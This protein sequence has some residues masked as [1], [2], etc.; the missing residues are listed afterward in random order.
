MPWWWWLLFGI[1]IGVPLGIF[2][3]LGTLGWLAREDIK[4]QAD[5]RR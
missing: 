1:F 3:T 4:T 2:G 5:H